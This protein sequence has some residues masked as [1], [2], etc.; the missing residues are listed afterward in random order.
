M[1]R[2]LDHLSIALADGEHLDEM[3]AAIAAELDYIHR[4]TDAQIARAKRVRNPVTEPLQSADR[5][6]VP[7]LVRNTLLTVADKTALCIAMGRIGRSPWLQIEDAKYNVLSSIGLAVTSFS[8][9]GHHIAKCTL[10]G[11]TC[12][13]C[14]YCYLCSYLQK[15]KPARRQYDGTFERALARGWF[16][17]AVTPSFECD[18]ERAGLRLVIKKRGPG[19]HSRDVLDY[20]WPFRAGGFSVRSPLTADPSGENLDRIE[21]CLDAPFTWLSRLRRNGLV[22]GY[23]AHRAIGVHFAPFWITPHQH[24][25]LITDQKITP[26]I[27][28]EMYTRLLRCYMKMAG[29]G[30][31]YPDLHISPLA[32]AKELKSWLHYMLR[33]IDLATP[34]ID[35]VR[36]KA[37]LSQVNFDLEEF[38]QGGDMVLRETT[39]PRGVGVLRV[40]SRGYLGTGETIT[41]TRV[42]DAAERK[43]RNQLGIPPASR[44]SKPAGRVEADRRIA[45]ASAAADAEKE[46]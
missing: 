5:S 15:Q 9:H 1:K 18:P 27:A 42:E 43:R 19:R 33:P 29:P 6:D 4:D 12:N 35:A 20:W 28:R 36:R 25:V 41:K 45:A 22:L 7:R 17:Y 10:R 44:P 3:D 21:A 2:D 23:Y 14:D 11:H 39:S 8:E 24:L 30:H 13:Q 37:D 26:G 38:Y 40:N 34:Y 16:V 31:Y 46:Y 32:E